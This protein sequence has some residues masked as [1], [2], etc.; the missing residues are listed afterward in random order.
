MLLG[1]LGSLLACGPDATEVVAASIAYVDDT[2]CADCHAYEFER[3]TGSHHDLAM[4]PATEATVLGD[5]EDAIF[6]EAGVRTRFFRRDGRFL[7]ETVG[8]DGELGE[9]EVGYVF[10]VDPLQQVL[11]ELPGGRQQCLTVAWDVA[12]ERW[13]SLYPG[14]SFAPDDPLHW[15][16]RYQ[17]WNLMCGDWGTSRLALK[18][19]A[20]PAAPFLHESFPLSAFDLM[21]FATPLV[22]GFVGIAWARHIPPARRE[23]AIAAVFLLFLAVA[24]GFSV[25]YL[26]WPVVFLVASSIGRG[27]FYSLL[28]GAFLY[29]TYA[30]WS[31]SWQLGHANIWVLPKN[32]RWTPLGWTLN[33]S[34]WS[35]VC[36]LTIAM[37]RD[38]LNAMRSSG[39]G[40]E[41]AEG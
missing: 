40:A 26:A 31:Q 24:P 23:Q 10:G 1:V 5:F 21:I 3:W 20:N 32:L 39:S 8:T 25:Q 36:L 38:L 30:H 22:V 29:V 12:D 18:L 6:E 34:T 13:F 37:G 15:S 28:S 11:I 27:A 4:Q 17:R 33:W 2:A 19:M 35:L 16:G 14:Q 9:F 41:A 7:V